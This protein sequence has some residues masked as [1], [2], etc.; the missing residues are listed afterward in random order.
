MFSPAKCEIPSNIAI[1]DNPLPSPMP[2]P[3]SLYPRR[4]CPSLCFCFSADYDLS[5]PFPPSLPPQPCHY[6]LFRLHASQPQITAKLPPRRSTTTSKQ[7]LPLI[8]RNYSVI[9]SSPAVP[10][11]TLKFSCRL[12]QSSLATTTSSAISSSFSA[13]HRYFL[14]PAS[15]SVFS[16]LFLPHCRTCLHRDDHPRLSITSATNAH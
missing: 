15:S 9:V 4:Q 16:T 2:C 13:D 14:R 12:A 3:R 7:L 8:P 6:L 5:L 10:C 11:P 1:H